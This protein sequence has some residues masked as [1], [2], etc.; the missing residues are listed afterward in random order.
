ML[1]ITEN[2]RKAV[3]FERIFGH[4]HHLGSSNGRILKDFCLT[5]QDFRPGRVFKKDLRPK[6]PKR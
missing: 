1:L 2:G 4:E 3:F 5:L 6:V